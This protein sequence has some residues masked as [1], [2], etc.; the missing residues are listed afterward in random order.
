M[1]AL[2]SLPQ[3]Q[4]ETAAEAPGSASFAIC[5]QT[6]NPLGIKPVSLTLDPSRDHREQLAQTMGEGE[7]N[8]RFDKPTDGR[9]F[10]LAAR[11]RERGLPI[12][13]HAVGTIHPDLFYFLRRSGFDVAHVAG[14]D[15]ASVEALVR[16]QAA[17]LLKPFGGHYQTA[18]DGRPGLIGSAQQSQAV[19]SP[20]GETS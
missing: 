1:S 11:I 15:P 4:A 5:L 16:E 3:T 2:P 20:T 18:A 7:V 12:R 14:R 8:I 17:Q 10:T 13:L 19:D 9:G 6:G